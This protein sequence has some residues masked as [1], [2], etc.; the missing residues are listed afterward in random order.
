M[1]WHLSGKF[2]LKYPDVAITPWRRYAKAFW[3][4]EL[5]MRFALACLAL[6]VPALPVSAQETAVN[7]QTLVYELRVYYP[8]PGKLAALNTRFREHTLGLFAKHG[9]RNVAYWNE[10]PT[11]AAPEGRVVYVLAYPSRAA[12]DVSWKA[13][14]ED[15]EW[16]SVAAASEAGGK[17]VTKVDS[18][19]MTLADYSPPLILKR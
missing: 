18:V 5:V 1:A 3:F 12:R 10:M 15:P 6:S 7:A 19:F 8:A 4:E 14:T 13:F 11:E 9:M 17:L 2:A 16:R